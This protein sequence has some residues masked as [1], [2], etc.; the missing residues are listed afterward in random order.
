M[1]Y[2]EDIDPTVGRTATR[3]V[4]N[5]HWQINR[6]ATFDINYT[7][8]ATDFRMDHQQQRALFATF[9]LTR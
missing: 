7:D 6:F 3:A 9:T 5:P 1:S 4:F 2:D 8:V